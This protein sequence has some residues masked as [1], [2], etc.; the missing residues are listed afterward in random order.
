FSGNLTAATSY[1]LTL[2]GTS[3]LIDERDLE[4]T[5]KLIYLNFWTTSSDPYTQPTTSLELNEFKSY[6]LANNGSIP[7][8]LQHLLSGRS[9]GGGIAFIDAVCAGN[10]YGLSAIDAVY[11]YP[12][13]TTTWDA[14][15]VTHEMG[16]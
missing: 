3:N 14:M 9:L 16:H 2:L 12:T 1:V 4:A 10:A 11:T 13:V 15:V 6:W 7:S 5:L 8:N